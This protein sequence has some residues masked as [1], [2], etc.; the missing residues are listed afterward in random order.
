[1]K[2]SSLRDT[3]ELD[4]SVLLQRLRER[5]AGCWGRRIATRGN[6]ERAAHGQ[7]QSSVQA[8]AAA[9]GCARRLTVCVRVAQ[10]IVCSACKS[11]KSLPSRFRGDLKI[12]F[13]P[14]VY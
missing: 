10:Y 6:S 13:E 5:R 12:L 8:R 4:S 2:Q 3:E 1:M 11:V 7:Q 14:I 9:T